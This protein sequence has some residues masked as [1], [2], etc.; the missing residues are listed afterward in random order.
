MSKRIPFLIGTYTLDTGSK[1]IY[2]SALDTDTGKMEAPVPVAEVTNPSFV[3]RSKKGDR[4][5][6]VIE[7]GEY[8]AAAQGGVA[9]LKLEDGKWV[10]TAEMHSGGKG[11]C[12]LALD[13]KKKVLAVANYTD[14]VMSIYKLDD[15]GAL[16]S[17]AGVFP[18]AGDDAAERT[19]HAHMCT[20]FD[21]ALWC[22]DLG[23]DRIRRYKNRCGKWKEIEPILLPEGCGPRHLCIHPSGDTVYVGCELNSHMYTLQ[24]KDG[25][26]TVVQDDFCIPDGVTSYIG[27]VRLGADGKVY[28]SNRG[29][30][31]VAVYE[32]D[33]STHLPGGRVLVTCPAVF[34][35]DIMIEGDCLLCGCQKSDK[36]VSLKK[37]A[38]GEYETADEFSLPKPVCLLPM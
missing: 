4:L 8:K 2:A 3:I 10:V 14:G 18:Y 32:P 34:P 9:S 26:W 5:Y 23:T 27:A 21:G 12:H 19:P 35:R 6:C 25:D 29:Y 17:V 11:P 28:V 33:A 1:G 30:D 38:A 15:D 24:K 7:C 31:S 13:E 20:F 16:E 22:N 37:N 36:V